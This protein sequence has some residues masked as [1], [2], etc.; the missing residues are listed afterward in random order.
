M[1]DMACDSIRIAHFITLGIGCRDFDTNLG[2]TAWVFNNFVFGRC[3]GAINF[4]S[5]QREYFAHHCGDRTKNRRIKILIFDKIPA[6][7]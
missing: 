5:P 2:C 7:A 6:S 4:L 3:A 1:S